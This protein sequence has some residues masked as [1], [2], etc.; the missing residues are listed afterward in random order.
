MGRDGERVGAVEMRAAGGRGKKKRTEAVVV[1]GGHFSRFKG[2]ASIRR[3]GN[4]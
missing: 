3:L 4:F 1:R 2:L